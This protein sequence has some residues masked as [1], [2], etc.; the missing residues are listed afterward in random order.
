[1]APPGLIARKNDI[2][3]RWLERVLRDGGRPDVSVHSLEVEPYRTK[4]YSALYRLKID[5]TGGDLPERLMLKLARPDATDAAARRRRRKEHGFYTMLAPLMADP[6]SPAV[7]AAACAE[8]ARHGHLLMADLTGSHERPP[9]GLPPTPEQARLSCIAFGGLHAAWWN[10]EDIIATVGQR[11]A[12]Y[13]EKRG[14]DAAAAATAFLDRYGPFLDR[15]IRHAVE[16]HAGSAG[17]LLGRAL[18]GPVSAIHG[19]AHPWNVL[20]PIEPGGP[21]LLLDWEGWSVDSPAFDLV[22]LI[23]LRFDTGL[24]RRLE[25]DLLDTWHATIAAGGV[26]GYS[27]D[28]LFDDYRRAI[29]RRASMPILRAQ[30]DEEPDSWFPVLSRVAMAWEDLR[31]DEVLP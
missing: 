4:P 6:V 18:A 30:R 1:M 19:D 7:Y 12:G 11:D 21:A 5:Q 2:T 24:R 26:T 17:A 20:T 29:V 25:S 23:V 15:S 10:H 22:S 31:C 27:R 28:D 3:A 16:R 14:T 13:V 9:R 8:D